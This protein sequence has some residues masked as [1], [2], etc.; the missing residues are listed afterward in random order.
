VII[1][2]KKTARRACIVIPSRN[3]V[4]RTPSSEYIRNPIFRKPQSR[5]GAMSVHGESSIPTIPRRVSVSEAE[6]VRVGEEVA[7]AKLAELEGAYE[8]ECPM[9]MEF[10][11]EEMG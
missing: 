5:R 4:A 7:G 3:V 10:R 11:G 9:H 8:R 2:E 6:V 1:Y